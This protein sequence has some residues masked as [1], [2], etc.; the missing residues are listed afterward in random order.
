VTDANLALGRVLPD[1][2][3]HIFGP[4]EDQPLDGAAAAA[5][6]AA[7]AAEVNAHAGA[8][9]QP[10][11]TPDEVAMGFIR[12]ANEAMCRPIR[13]LTQMR[14]HDATQHALACFGGAG[15]QHACAIAAALGV[16]TIFVHRYAGVLSAVGIG[17]A[18]VVEEAQEPSAAA[19]GGAGGAAALEARLAALEAR[20]LG[21]LAEQGFAPGSTAA[22]RFLNLR[23]EGT[24][25]AVMTPCP[26]DGDYA[27]AFE[28]A[29]KV[30]SPP[31]RSLRDAVAFSHALTLRFRS[32]KKRRVCCLGGTCCKNAGGCLTWSVSP[33][34]ACSASLGL[35]WRVGRFW[36]TTSA[37]APQG[38]AW[39]SPPPRRRRPRRA[40][41]PRPPP[42]RRPT[43]SRAG[44]SPR[45][46]TCWPRCAPATRSP[47]PPF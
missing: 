37:C 1:F 26:A 44:G 15:G 8:Q 36:W 11:K 21:A 23:Y 35:C 12:V 17:L 47:A 10:P 28:A 25:V 9:G 19:L 34:R 27:A 22:Q 40:R 31:G 5:A 16:K 30:S 29:Y 24:D 2:F 14:G 46:P 33:L 20:A 18:E 43:S 7:L 4:G 38:A 42:P 6:L 41:S 45:P 13:A 39:S 3:P 32:S